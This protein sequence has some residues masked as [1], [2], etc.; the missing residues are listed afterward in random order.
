MQFQA[1]SCVNW[2]KMAHIALTTTSV[3]FNNI[4]TRDAYG[5]VGVISTATAVCTVSG[6]CSGRCRTS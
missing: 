3:F 5:I 1:I 4:L 6:Q 2:V